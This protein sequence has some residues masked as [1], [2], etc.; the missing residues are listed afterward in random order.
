MMNRTSTRVLG[1]PRYRFV[2]DAEAIDCSAETATKTGSSS[3]F[4]ICRRNGTRSAGNRWS[5]SVR[6]G[7]LL[8]AVDSYAADHRCSRASG[9]VAHRRPYNEA[10]GFD[11]Q[12]QG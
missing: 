12:I 11:R 1:W 10:Q 3:T 9:P 8:P 5:G 2:G 6:L 4:P 7:H